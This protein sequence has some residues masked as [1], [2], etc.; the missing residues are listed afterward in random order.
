MTTVI[1]FDVNE[2]LLD[3]SVL[4]ESFEDVFDTAT[5]R[6]MWIAT[7]LQ[8]SFVGGL[9]G[10]YVDF[11]TAQRA[12][13]TMLAQRHGVDLTDAAVDRVVS[14]MSSLPPHPEV[15][16]ALA[17]WRK[18]SLKV[19]ALTNSPPAK[20][21]AQLTHAGIRQHFLQAISADSVYGSSPRRSPTSPSH[22]KTPAEAFDERL[23]S[24]EQPVLRQSN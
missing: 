23:L 11:T 3:L 20:A 19:V 22:G 9:T 5:L 14:R 8:L 1:A 10:D 24:P 17:S 4:D 21:E 7:M 12:A 16:A 15:D 13:L 6:P 2:T 18:T